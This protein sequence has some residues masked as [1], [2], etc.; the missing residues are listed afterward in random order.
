MAA[1][2]FSPWAARWSPRIRVSPVWCSIARRSGDHGVMAGDRVVT[3]ACCGERGPF[4][5]ALL[6]RFPA[7]GA[8]RAAGWRIG[9]AWGVALQ[10]DPLSSSLVGRVGNGGRRE[11]RRCVG[12]PRG[13]EHVLTGPGFD[14]A[15]EV[16]HRDGVGDLVD[17]GEVV[18]DEE[19]GETEFCLEFPE[20][21]ENLGSDRYVECGHGFVEDE[22]VGLKR[23]GA[24]DGHSLAFAA[25]E[26]VGVVLDS[27]RRDSD[28][29]QQ[30][31]C[32]SGSFVAAELS[33]DGP[34]LGDS[35]AGGDPGVEGCERVLEDQLDRRLCRAPRSAAQF[36]EVLPVQHHAAGVRLGQAEQQ[37][38]HSGLAAARFADERVGRAGVEVEVDTV[39]RLERAATTERA[40]CSIV[41][42]EAAGREH[43]VCVHDSSSA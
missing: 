27:I 36:E 42:D 40:R 16:H 31:G 38:G 12:V 22:H 2:G 23:E 20:Q 8:E 26:L 18:G 25:G 24:G 11:K 7:A 6:F 33:L 1:D 15:S 14:D 39:D 28:P 10:H 37:S 35:V 30:P 17:D 19:V 43:D 29:F 32:S 13:A 5:G 21:V 41:L 4:L 34:R 9:R 3:A